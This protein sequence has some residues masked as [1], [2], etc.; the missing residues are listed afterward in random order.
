[1]TQVFASFA[2]YANS[3]WLTPYNGIFDEIF[4]SSAVSTSNIN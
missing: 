4:S 2:T 1:M 3:S